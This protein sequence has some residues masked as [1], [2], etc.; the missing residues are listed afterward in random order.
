VRKGYSGFRAD[1]DGAPTEIPRIF[2]LAWPRGQN[3]RWGG[4]LSNVIRNTEEPSK[5][6]EGEL[7][8]ASLSQHE[9]KRWGRANAFDLL[10]S[11]KAKLRG[12][13]YYGTGLEER[14]RSFSTDPR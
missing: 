13:N 14:G 11:V 3:P 10:E 8:R 4:Y 1:S 5:E 9:P 6:K 2:R 12:K 7:M